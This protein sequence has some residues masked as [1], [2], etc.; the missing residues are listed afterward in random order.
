MT[1]SS[2]SQSKIDNVVS[3]LKSSYPD[4]KMTGI[5]TDLGKPDSL[6]ADLDARRGGCLAWVPSRQA[7]AND[8]TL[9]D[10]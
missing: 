5:A 9:R 8:L 4:R 1:I 6:E 3:T 2:S 7:P 10:W